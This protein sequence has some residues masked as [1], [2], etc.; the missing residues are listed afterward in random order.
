[1]WGTDAPGMQPAARSGSIG[2]TPCPSTSPSSGFQMFI[3]DAHLDLAFN[4]E[5]GRDV[6]RPASEQPFV[7]NETAT[8]GLPDLRQGKVGLVLATIFCRPASGEGRSGYTDASGAIEQARSQLSHYRRLEAAG[9]VRM[10]RAAPELP[11]PNEPADR[12]GGA[13]PI[14]LLLEGADAIGVDVA[15]EDP[16]SPESWF[17]A[18]V[19]VVGLAWGA[20]RYAGG[21]GAPGGLTADGRQLVG[22]LDTLGIIHDASHLAEQSLDELLELATGP[23]CASHSNC[24]AIVREDPSGRHLP[25]RHISAIA[26]RGGVI[27]INFFDRFLLPPDELARRRASFADVAEHVRHVCDRVGNTGHVGIGSDLDGGFGLERVP[28]EMTSAADLPM[29]AE[30]LADG[31]FSDVQIGQILGGNWLT[32]LKRHLPATMLPP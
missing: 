4:V 23:V 3:V 6:T 16:A 11:T 17:A 25:D 26:G 9:E 10:V 7:Q 32:F 31:G 8:T 30:F 14:V 13:I 20:T 18:G 29:L 12:E 19:R 1:M 2:D 28:H 5:R 15:V 27:G 21:T 22:R 24:R